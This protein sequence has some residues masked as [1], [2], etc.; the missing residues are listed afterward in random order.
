MSPL[1]DFYYPKKNRKE[2]LETICYFCL[3]PSWRYVW[4]RL[5]LCKVFLLF[6]QWTISVGIRQQKKK[7]SSKWDAICLISF[8]SVVSSSSSYSFVRS[9]TGTAKKIF[10][11]Y[12]TTFF[13]VS[14]TFTHFVLQSKDFLIRFF[15]STKFSTLF[16]FP[17]TEKKNF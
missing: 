2:I 1:D 15:L 8:G 5:I 13:F 11:Q 7:L 16:L 4:F 12:F 9:I 10:F 17:K 3:Y 6:Q 14:F